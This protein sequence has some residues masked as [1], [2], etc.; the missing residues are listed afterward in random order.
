MPR[1]LHSTNEIVRQLPVVEPNLFWRLI[2]DVAASVFNE[3]SS[4][5][6]GL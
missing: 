2:L 4:N 5:F 6:L 1:T 3:K